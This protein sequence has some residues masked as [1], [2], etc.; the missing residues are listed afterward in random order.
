MEKGAGSTKWPC[1]LVGPVSKLINAS[2]IDWSNQV[3]IGAFGTPDGFWKPS[4][5]NNAWDVLLGVVWFGIVW[6]GVR[7]GSSLVSNGG[8][9]YLR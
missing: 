6:Y 8:E 4:R 1:R 5:R 3:A 2:A 7:P 9:E